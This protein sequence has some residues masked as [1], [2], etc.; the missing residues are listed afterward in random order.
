M[1]ALKGE[2]LTEQ[3]IMKIVR[4]YANSPEGKKQ[5]KETYGVDYEDKDDIAEAKKAGNQMKQ[6]LFKHISQVIK[7][8]K[9]EDII[10]EQPKVVDGELQIN[11]S[12]SE[13]ALGR[14]S[15]FPAKYP[16]GV[17]DIVLHL[18]R[19]YHAR[20]YVYS[21]DVSKSGNGKYARIRSRKDRDPNPF[22]KDAVDEFNSNFLKDKIKAEL[23][24]EYKIR[25]E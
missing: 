12:F 17:E 7:S 15:L 8:F 13:E 9:I 18:S 22:L 10:V 2:K 3:D 6:I 4:E 23:L 5:I 19:G 25:K 16:D 20:D 1:R 14:S 24:G 21:Y 11:I